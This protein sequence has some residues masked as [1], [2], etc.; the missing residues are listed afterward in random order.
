[1]RLAE[2]RPGWGPRRDGRTRGAGGGVRTIDSMLVR[3][4]V[5]A[6]CCGGWGCG[7]YGASNRPS[8]RYM[9]SRAEPYTVQSDGMVMLHY[10]L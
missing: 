8:P 7:V 5:L 10:D 3:V 1:M 4:M 2:I 6:L 9:L